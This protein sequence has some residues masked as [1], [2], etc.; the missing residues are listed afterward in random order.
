VTEELA[1]ELAK[2]LTTEYDLREVM[3]VISPETPT[4][5]SVVADFQDGGGNLMDS[6]ARIEGLVETNQQMGH[7]ASFDG[8][9][10]T[11]Q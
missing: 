10:V 1:I 9:Y 8:R 11:I 4:D 5:W 3:I 6:V 7:N 2:S